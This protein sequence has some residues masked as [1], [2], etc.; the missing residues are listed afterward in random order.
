MYNY[1]IHRY[2]GTVHRSKSNGF[3][4]LALDMGR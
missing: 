2:S 4:G 3:F 1:S